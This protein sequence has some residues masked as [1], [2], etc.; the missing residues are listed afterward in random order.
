MFLQFCIQH[1]YQSTA[2]SLF[3]FLF[4]CLFFASLQSIML[5]LLF[6]HY[7]S[8]RQQAAGY[9]HVLQVMVEFTVSLLPLGRRENELALSLFFSLSNHQFGRRK[10]KEFTIL[11]TCNILP[12]WLKLDCGLKLVGELM[13]HQLTLLKEALQKYS[14]WCATMLFNLFQKKKS[15]EGKTI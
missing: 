6:L 10:L 5:P 4:V 14:I 3:G 13:L 12:I 1:L 8:K 7:L 15:C 9:S 11:K 2:I